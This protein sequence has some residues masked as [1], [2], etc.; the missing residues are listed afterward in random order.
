MRQ[1]PS[2]TIM[3][4]ALVA[5]NKAHEGNQKE[6]SPDQEHP[7]LELT[8]LGDSSRKLNQ[9]SLPGF[10]SGRHKLPPCCLVCRISQQQNQVA[11]AG[12]TACFNSSIF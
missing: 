4:A 12:I 11:G 3:Q 5:L 1:R 9:E 2:Y 7:W 10:L 6:L 8:K